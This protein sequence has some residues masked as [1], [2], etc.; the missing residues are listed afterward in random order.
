MPKH[1]CVEYQRVFALLQKDGIFRPDKIPQLEEMS[2][3]LK[4]KIPIISNFLY[5]DILIVSRFDY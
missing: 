4:S 1:F 2:A 3:F 5:T